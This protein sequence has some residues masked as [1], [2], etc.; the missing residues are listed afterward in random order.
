MATKNFLRNHWPAISITV[1]AGAIVIAAIVILL[2][3]PPRMIVMATGPKGGAYYEIGTRYREALAK[4]GV[5]VR[6]LPTAGSL[7]NL[8]L[9]RDPHSGVSIG[10]IQG[11]TFCAAEKCRPGP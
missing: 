11:G 4:A 2:T 7:E 10:L 6:L 1:T 3:L 5:E 9:L 8:A